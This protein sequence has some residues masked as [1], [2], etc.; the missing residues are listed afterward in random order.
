[1]Q[2]CEFNNI[3]RR[4]GYTFICCYHPVKQHLGLTL[5]SKL[6]T[7]TPTHHQSNTLH[8][9]MPSHITRHFFLSDFFLLTKPKQVTTF[10]KTKILLTV[11]FSA[12]Q[13]S[14]REIN[15]NNNNRCPS[16]PL[17]Y[18]LL[19][20]IITFYLFFFF[21]SV[22]PFFFALSSASPF[23]FTKSLLKKKLGKVPH[24][25]INYTFF[26]QIFPNQRQLE[27]TIQKERI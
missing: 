19:T 10:C 6:N 7:R 15:S 5:H 12:L 26:S 13:N 14:S 24:I 17:L 8:S 16:D 27:V 2:I 25:Q 4:K 23:C 11:L 3:L 22:T 1:M 21:Q 9:S 20:T 18:I